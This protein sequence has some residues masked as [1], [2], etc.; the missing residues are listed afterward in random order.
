VHLT[1]DSPYSKPAILFHWVIAVLV[2]VAY[3][4]IEV[5]GPKGTESRIAWNNV[6]YW[7]GIATLMCA[8]F[9]TA[10]RLWHG[11][12]A[13]IE[14]TKILQFLA[15]LAHLSLY[16]FIF[17]QPLL[18]ILMLNA[19]GHVIKITAIGL[20]FQLVSSDPMAQKIIYAVHVAIGKGFYFIIGIHALAAIVHH[21]FLKD[22][23]LKRIL[24]WRT[25]AA[26]KKS[27]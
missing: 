5:R 18:G 12:P 10:W 20:N 17:L 14:Q 2:A 15:R 7:A 25:A 16:V 1:N 26:F 13:E 3:L 27:N 21:C 8:F 19:A 11:V 6:H 4:A 24:P 22:H 9:R 23:V